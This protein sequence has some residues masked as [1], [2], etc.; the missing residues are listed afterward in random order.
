MNQ[1]EFIRDVIYNLKH[2]YGSFAMFRKLV[3][4][5]FDPKTGQQSFTEYNFN[6]SRIIPLP[7][8]ERQRWWRQLGVLKVGNIEYGDEEFLIDSRDVPS[9]FTIEAGMQMFFN[10]RRF[11]IKTVENYTHAFRVVGTVVTNTQK[12]ITMN[13]A[14]ELGLEGSV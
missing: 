6:I 5:A 4:V 7:V 9:G 10:S 14:D 12:T 1:L 2:E 11:Q 8:E 3:P 13:V